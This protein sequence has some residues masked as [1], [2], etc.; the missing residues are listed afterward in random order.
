VNA[1]CLFR[2]KKTWGLIVALGTLLKRPLL[3]RIFSNRFRY[4]K[5]PLVMGKRNASLSSLPKVCQPAGGP[6]FGGSSRPP[7]PAKY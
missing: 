5:F 7:S 4:Q 2:R 1:L 6:T 3:P